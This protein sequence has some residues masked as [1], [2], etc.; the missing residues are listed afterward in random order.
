MS[1][2]DRLPEIRARIDRA[3][4][5]RHADRYMVLDVD[6]PALVEAVQAVLDLHQ[7]YD[8]CIDGCCR[9]CDSCEHQWPCPTYHAITA[10]L[11]EEA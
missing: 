8:Q 6:A 4:E 7:F 9:Y 3:R 11:G 10:A 1:A 5:D 2:S